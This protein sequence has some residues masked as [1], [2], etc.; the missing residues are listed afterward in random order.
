MNRTY[1]TSVLITASFFA[2]ASLAIHAGPPDLELASPKNDDH[3]EVPKPLFFWKSSPGTQS[4]EVYVDDVKMG[5]VSPASIPMMSYGLTT[6]LPPGQ[7]H[8]YV[9]AIPAV[10]AAI[11][12]SASAFTIDPSENWPD[13]A[14]GPFERYGENPIVR[15][16]GTGWEEVNTYNPGVLFD[17]DKFRMLYRAQGQAPGTTRV[18][19]DNISREGYAESIDGVTFARNPGPLIEATEPFEKK[20]GCEDARFFKQDG[21][22]YTFYTGNNARGGIALCEA[23]STDGLSW[24]KLGPI[25]DNAKNGALVQR[26]I[27]MGHSFG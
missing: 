21:T 6:P 12:S 11:T 10:G 16:R 26:N 18:K 9:K 5:T 2:F 15:P 13:W 19:P 25:V 7:H 4:Y 1:S 3:F 17:Q 14:I 20:Y 22:Y 24:K 23:T 27:D 8:W